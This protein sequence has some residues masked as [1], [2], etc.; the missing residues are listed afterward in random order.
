MP[1]MGVVKLFLVFYIEKVCDWFFTSADTLSYK[2]AAHVWFAHV[3]KL[4]ISQSL[5]FLYVFWGVVGF[6]TNSLFVIKKALE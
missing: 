6:H 4:S 1:A 2:C 5:A 3:F